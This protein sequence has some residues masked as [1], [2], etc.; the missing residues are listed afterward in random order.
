[1]L[2]INGQEVELN[3]NLGPYGAFLYQKQFNSSITNDIWVMTGK[4]IE[5]N[6]ILDSI[7]LLQMVFIMGGFYGKTTFEQFLKSIPADYNV[8][9]DAADII[10]K[11]QESYLPTKAQDTKED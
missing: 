9:E 5:E 7:G 2:K 6:F 10:T 1:M 3:K 4:G 11:A 8:I